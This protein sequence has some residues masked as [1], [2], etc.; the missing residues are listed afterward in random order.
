[1]LLRVVLP[2]FSVLLIL[3]FFTRVGAL[4]CWFGV[5]AVQGANPA[6]LY[7]GDRLLDLLLYWSIF[8]PLGTVW[9]LESS[10]IKSAAPPLPTTTRWAGW[11]IT[12]QICFVYWF[13]ALAKS[14]P[15]W[16]QNHNALFYALSIEYLTSPWGEYLRHFPGLL[17]WLTAATL[18]FEFLG[19]LLLFVPFQRD[20]F[21]LAAVVLFLA[22]HLVGMQALLR[23]GFFPWVCAVAWL[24]FIPASTWDAL[25]G[26][27][28]Q[29]APSTKPSGWV[30]L[31]DRGLTALVFFS[32]ADALLW[33]LVTFRNSDSDDWLKRRDPT[34]AIL[35]L[36][37]HWRMYAPFPLPDHGWLVIPADLADGTQ[38]DLFTGHSVS[39][40]TPTDIR[41]YLGRDR[42]R[43]YLADLFTNQVP[44][45]LQHYG[46]YL[47]NQWN[48]AHPDNKVRSISIIFMKMST[49]PD[50]TVTGPERVT[51]YSRK[52]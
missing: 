11:A 24:I 46:D 41:D 27:A 40:A 50:L 15:V 43:I 51:L 25:A 39:W 14:D 33:N 3:G 16:T 35:H 6:I 1:M 42:W 17:R 23:I 9:S 7:G 37:Q 32:I 48:Q 19:P 47:T 5:L 45:R 10:L 34:A 29:R 20:R 2:I 52:Y 30:R 13:A 38:V 4:V 8:L 36:D 21:R 49:H 12:L 18:W 22:F 28:A 31:L 44:E 26:P